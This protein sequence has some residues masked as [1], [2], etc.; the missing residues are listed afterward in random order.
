ML[1]Y[2]RPCSEPRYVHSE[3]FTTSWAIPKK[4]KKTLFFAPFAL[5]FLLSAESNVSLYRLLFSSIGCTVTSTAAI[6]TIPIE[7]KASTAAVSFQAL[8]RNIH[9]GT[10][11]AQF[12]FSNT[13]FANGRQ[14]RCK[15]V[16]LCRDAVG[17]RLEHLLESAFETREITLSLNA[18]D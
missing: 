5:L 7:A 4:F 15:V 3:N 13:I 8:F 18:E 1:H 9:S 12:L 2:A 16:S 17:M 10:Q 14:L 6:T 11:Y